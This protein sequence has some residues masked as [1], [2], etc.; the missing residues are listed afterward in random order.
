MDSWAGQQGISPAEVLNAG[1]RVFVV[2]GSGALA[3]G[4]DAALA[5]N[6]VS[7]DVYF[8][9]DPLLVKTATRTSAEFKGT[10]AARTYPLTGLSGG[11]TYYWRIDEIDAL[12]EEG[13]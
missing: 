9:T 12:T 6:A 2:I 4:W 11:T 13:Q 8:G 10:Q 1:K 7:R 3:L 5:G